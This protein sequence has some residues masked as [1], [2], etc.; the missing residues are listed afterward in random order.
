MDN[1]VCFIEPRRME[2][3]LCS[4]ALHDMMI[5][6]QQQRSRVANRLWLLVDCDFGFDAFAQMPMD[7][8]V[9]Q[10]AGTSRCRVSA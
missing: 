4:C 2:D 5:V 7:P 9:R 10:T 8:V 6:D 3:S 1:R